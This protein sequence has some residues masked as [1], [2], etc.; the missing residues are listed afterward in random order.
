[1]LPRPNREYVG[2]RPPL[3]D[4][5]RVRLIRMRRDQVRRCKRATVVLVAGLLA[6]ACTAI[7]APPSSATGILAA[8]SPSRA[9]SIPPTPLGTM[10]P[11]SAAVAARATSVPREHRYVAGAEVAVGRVWLVDL[12]LGTS[13]DV[14]AA[15]GEPK[16]SYFAP[17]FSESRD[18]A[19]LLVGANGPNDRAA[20]YLVEVSTGRVQ[21]LYEDREIQAIG[22]LSGTISPDGSRYA[23]MDLAGVRVGD[24]SGG[25]TRQLVPH[26][27]PNRVGGMW[28]PRAWS[29]DQTRLAIGRSSEA[30]NEIALVEVATGKLMRIGEG[31]SVSWLVR[32]PELLVGS[33]IDAFGGTS[34][35]YTYDVLTG[36]KIVLLAP[37][38]LRISSLAWNPSADSFLYTQSSQPVAEGDV[39]VRTLTDSDS[40]AIASSR[41]VWEAWWSADGSRI[42]AI[43][44][45]ADALGPGVANLDVLELPSGRLIAT[46]CRGDPRAKCP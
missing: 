8:P 43:A 3:K 25:P 37:G 5:V 1:M 12:E 29:P 36:R 16:Q 22:A 17:S 21:L 42:F 19:R 38:R 30:E 18:G 11:T 7:P 44:P 4:P 20:L 28:S 41:R 24:T 13:T 31:V 46:L 9:A 14:I 27:E 10:V 6:S 32:A 23:F 26:D 2:H 15:H 45:R 40:K 39:Y 33:G 35:I 34:T